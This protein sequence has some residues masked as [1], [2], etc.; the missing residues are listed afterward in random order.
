M[1]AGISSVARYI[2]KMRG[3]T[4]SFSEV[5]TTE[6]IKNEVMPRRMNMMD[7]PG[8]S[9]PRIYTE[10]NSL[11]VHGINANDYVIAFRNA[12]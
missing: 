9:N 11:D 8:A 10:V 5:F 7:P 2:Q 1:G 3:L 12:I 6:T 4:R